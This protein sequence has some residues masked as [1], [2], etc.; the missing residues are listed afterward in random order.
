MPAAPLSVVMGDLKVECRAF[1]LLAAGHQAS[2]PTP[3]QILKTA[4]VIPFDQLRMTDIE[5]V[6]GKNASLG[7][8]INQL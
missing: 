8:M 5:T 2:R 4:W 6:G 1:P 7:E 3:E